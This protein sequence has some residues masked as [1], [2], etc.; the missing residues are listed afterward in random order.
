VSGPPRLPT[1]RCAGAAVD[2]RREGGEDAG[3]SRGRHSEREDLASVVVLWARGAGVAIR[4]AVVSVASMTASSASVGAHHIAHP[5]FFRHPLH[6]RSTNRGATSNRL[7]SIRVAIPLSAS[8]VASTALATAALYERLESGAELCSG[9]SRWSRCRR[10]RGTGSWC[11][12]MALC[13][14]TQMVRHAAA[15]PV[16]RH[17][18]LSP[19]PTLA[20]T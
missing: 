1:P 11:V 9:Q 18:S 20:P 12:L 8:Q 17:Q 5:A 16:H 2:P 19:T 7:E 10:S 6:L 4:H 15:E 14:R 13:H 3:P